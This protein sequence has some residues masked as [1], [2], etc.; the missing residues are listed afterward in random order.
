[1]QNNVCGFQRVIGRVQVLNI[2]FINNYIQVTRSRFL[3]GATSKRD[4]GFTT[5]LPCGFTALATRSENYLIEKLHH[6]RVSGNVVEN[7]HAYCVCL[8]NAYMAFAFSKQF[9]NPVSYVLLFIF[10]HS[11]PSQFPLLLISPPYCFHIR[12]L[13]PPLPFLYIIYFTFSSVQL[14]PCLCFVAFPGPYNPENLF[15]S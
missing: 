14:P 3:L 10:L 1:M 11:T 8:G 12:A 5:W 15:F 7:K 13:L 9:Q 6:T 2:S 4:Y